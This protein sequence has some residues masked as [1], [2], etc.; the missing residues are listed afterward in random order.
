MF[1]H[2]PESRTSNTV[3]DKDYFSVIDRAATEY[4]LIMKE[5]MHIK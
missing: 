3:C 1:K 2:L 5:A 4:Q